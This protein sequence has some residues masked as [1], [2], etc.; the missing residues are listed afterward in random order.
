MTLTG[1]ANGSPCEGF[2]HLE[3]RL[4]AGSGLRHTHLQSAGPRDA[5]SPLPPSIQQR[6]LH[7]PLEDSGTGRTNGLITEHQHAMFCDV[8]MKTTDV[9]TGMQGALFLSLSPQWWRDNLHAPQ[10]EGKGGDRGPLRSGKETPSPMFQRLSVGQD[11]RVRPEARS[12]SPIDI[13]YFY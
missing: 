9:P 2:S 6:L 13:S 11:T 3:S 4:L 12:T 5:P 8:Y 7:P 1:W 10:R